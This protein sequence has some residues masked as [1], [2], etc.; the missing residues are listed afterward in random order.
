MKKKEAVSEAK[1]SFGIRLAPSLVTK[2]KHLAVDRGVMVNMV[3]EEAIID[4]LK[5]NKAL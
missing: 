3:L 4:Y 1:K 2:L 5:K